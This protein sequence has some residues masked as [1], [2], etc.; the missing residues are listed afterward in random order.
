L[1]LTLGVGALEAAP[2]QVVA[3]L[4]NTGKAPDLTQLTA[5]LNRGW[6]VKQHSSTLSGDGMFP[7]VLLVF[8]MSP[9]SDEVLSRTE[10]QLLAEAQKQ[11][12]RRLAEVRMEYARKRAEWLA[13]QPKVE[14]Q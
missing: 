8:I 11:E 6:I 14:K 2:E 12:E 4:S 13:K 1:G 5:L 9:P 7:N 3:I 10:A